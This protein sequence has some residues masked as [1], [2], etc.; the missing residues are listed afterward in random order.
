MDLERPRTGLVSVL[1]TEARPSSSTGGVVPL[2]VTRLVDDA[3]LFPPGN[4]PM[5]R[6]LAE[7]ARH[8]KVWYAGMV[9]PFVCSAARLEE[10]RRELAAF[11]LEAPLDVALISSGTDGV[12]QALTAAAALSPEVTVVSVDVPLGPDSPAAGAQ[13]AVDALD[14]LLPR[15]VTAYVEIPAP[16]GGRSHSPL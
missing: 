11:P 10:L 12:T 16:T 9:G 4:A 1:P 14:G 7:H 13:R 2:L 8:R 15:G 3:A 6:A 5:G